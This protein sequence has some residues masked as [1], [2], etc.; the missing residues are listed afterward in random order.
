MAA[1]MTAVVDASKCKSFKTLL[2]TKSCLWEAKAPVF[3]SFTVV[4][5]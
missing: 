2:G 5:V 3:M 4:Q 1:G